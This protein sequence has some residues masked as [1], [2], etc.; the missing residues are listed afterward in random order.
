MLPLTHFLQE[1]VNLRDYE[2]IFTQ[3]KNTLKYLFRDLFIYLEIYLGYRLYIFLNKN[4]Y[5]KKNR[6]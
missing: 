4:I 1:K 2:V 5:L 3:V 6:S